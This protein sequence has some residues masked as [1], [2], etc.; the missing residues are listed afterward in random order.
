M[1]S[2]TSCLPRFVDNSWGVKPL[3]CGS[4]VLLFKSV[5][6]L[7]K[8]SSWLS[9]ILSFTLSSILDTA[10]KGLSSQV[11]ISIKSD[12]ISSALCADSCSLVHKKF[13]IALTYG[14]SAMYI[15]SLYLRSSCFG[16]IFSGLPA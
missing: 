1:L 4:R 10:S 16:S 11:I 15:S 5:N 9:V 14:V 3:F 8:S 6:S 12:I 13:I 2:I 7:I